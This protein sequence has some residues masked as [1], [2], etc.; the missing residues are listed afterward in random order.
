MFTSVILKR[1]LKYTLRYTL[2]Y[3]LKYTLNI[4]FSQ[5]LESSDQIKASQL[6]VDVVDAHVPRRGQNGEHVKVIV[7]LRVYLV[8][9]LALYPL[10]LES[11]KNPQNA[12]V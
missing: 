6:E 11:F 9:S 5:R 3:T 10:P 4:V 2:K 1:A 12:N 7:H 8:R